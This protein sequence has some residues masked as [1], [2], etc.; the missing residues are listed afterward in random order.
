MRH[1][2]H[3]GYAER[4]DFHIILASFTFC[5]SSNAHSYVISTLDQDL[6]Q[7]FKTHVSLDR[8]MTSWAIPDFF[9][10][11]LTCYTFSWHSF[12]CPSLHIQTT[13]CPLFTSFR[14]YSFVLQYVAC[15]PMTNFLYKTIPLHMCLVLPSISKYC[16]VS[17]MIFRFGYWIMW[18]IN[19]VIIFIF[20]IPTR[21][22]PLLP[23]VPHL[24][25]GP[26]HQA[27]P[28]LRGPRPCQLHPETRG[29]H[30]SP[31]ERLSLQVHARH[32]NLL[33]SSW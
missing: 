3:K 5:T 25:R 8:A 29:L 16:V 13:K 9:F 17:I 22:H 33:P 6:T 1:F 28:L 2:T 30:H 32:H 11:P 27:G 10:H 20:Q 18:L 19:T 31:E 24:R 21:R 4:M 12:L 7:V 26:G 15:H 23:A 14:I